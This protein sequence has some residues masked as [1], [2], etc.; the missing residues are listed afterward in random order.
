MMFFSILDQRVSLKV[1]LLIHFQNSSATVRHL[2]LRALVVVAT[3]GRHFC[4]VSRSKLGDQAPVTLGIE[5]FV[6]KVR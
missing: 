5:G 1:S 2:C 3:H 4:S 6:S